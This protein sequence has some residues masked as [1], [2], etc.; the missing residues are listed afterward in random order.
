MSKSKKPETIIIDHGLELEAETLESEQD[1]DNTP[2]AEIV[3]SDSERRAQETATRRERAETSRC[4]AETRE[5]IHEGRQDAEAPEESWGQFADA[6]VNDQGRIVLDKEQAEAARE[7][8]TALKSDRRFT[9]PHLAIGNKTAAEYENRSRTFATETEIIILP[10]GK[11]VFASYCSPASGVHRFFDGLMTRLS[12]NRMAKVSRS[13]WK[14]VYET[15][16]RIPIIENADPEVVLTPFIPSVDA[17]DAL[18]FN[19]GEKPI[20]NFGAVP[21]VA[22]W[23]LPE[24]IRF[25]EKTVKEIADAHS[26]G[27]TFGEM[28]LPNVLITSSGEPV[29]AFPETRYDKDVPVLEA[30]ARDLRDFIHSAVSALR[31]SEGDAVDIPEIAKRLVV[32]HPDENVRS[33][34][35]RL[36][37]EKTPWFQKLI[38][39]IHEFPRLG[40]SG[41]DYEAVLEAIKDLDSGN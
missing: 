41:K 26:A 9:P 28:I 31:K 7:S 27:Q 10:N 32:S 35:I 3:T 29:I 5:T 12:G 39:P 30:K 8:V 25:A 38:R 22:G 21:Q 1:F 14:K 11:K 18:A 24:K 15:Q 19:K 20:K 13:E 34:I 36:C 37:Q 23:G 40:T 2:T 16:S 6:C 33:E 4:L 17:H